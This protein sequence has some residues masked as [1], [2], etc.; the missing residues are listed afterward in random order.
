[1]YAEAIYLSGRTDIHINY[2]PA[3][4]HAFDVNYS[5]TPDMEK[6]YYSL[7]V[8]ISDLNRSFDLGDFWNIFRRLD[9]SIE[10]QVYTNLRK[11]AEDQHD[12]E[13]EDDQ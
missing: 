3:P 5:V 10:M 11:I 12:K 4:A 8:T 6:H 9:D 13:T 2:G 7:Y 1:L